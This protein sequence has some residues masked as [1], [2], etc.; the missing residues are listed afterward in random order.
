M[1]TSLF[2]KSPA[3]RLNLLYAR[4]SQVAIPCPERILYSST[5]APISPSGRL[6]KLISAIY[7]ST[8]RTHSVILSSSKI[9]LDLPEPYFKTGLE[10]NEFCMWITS[11]PLGVEN[12]KTSSKRIVRNLDDYIETN[13]I[14]IF[15]SLLQL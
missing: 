6:A 5:P 2:A 7:P 8:F 11:E 10:N 3:A 9:S 14:S 12:A 13:Q 1:T 15:M 4:C